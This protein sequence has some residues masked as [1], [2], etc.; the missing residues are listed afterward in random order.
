MSVH[1]TFCRFSSLFSDVFSCLF[2]K[3]QISPPANYQHLNQH[4]LCRWA[5]EPVAQTQTN[6]KTPGFILNYYLMLLA[7]SMRSGRFCVNSLPGCSLCGGVGRCSLLYPTGGDTQTLHVE[8]HSFLRCCRSLQDVNQH[9]TK[10]FVGL[11][12]DVS[13]SSKNSYVISKC[14]KSFL[15]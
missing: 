12:Q 3:L 2:A 6:I 10:F 5:V 4:I 8:A 7:C 11:T 1:I 9:L 14:S 13:E 15:L